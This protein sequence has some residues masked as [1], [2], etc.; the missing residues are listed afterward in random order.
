MFGICKWLN[1]VQSLALTR[2]HL[3][4]IKKLRGSK[5]SKDIVI[6]L[7]YEV[8]TC[9]I[10]PHTLKKQRCSRYLQVWWI[11]QVAQAQI[12]KKNEIERC[13]IQVWHQWILLFQQPE[14]ATRTVRTCK[15]IGTTASDKN[16]S[17]PTVTIARQISV[18]FF[19]KFLQ[20]YHQVIFII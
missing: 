1:T 17:W 11:Q 6:S 7:L 8:L 16:N 18:F 19:L 20:T 2:F 3:S 5:S 9:F 15:V 13:T 14:P 12:I 10:V 4:T